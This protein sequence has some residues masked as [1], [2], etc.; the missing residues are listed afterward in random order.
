MIPVK[1]VAKCIWV[2]GIAITN[3]CFYHGIFAAT[4]VAALSL[5]SDHRI[6]FCWQFVVVEQRQTNGIVIN[7]HCLY[8]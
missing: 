8:L 4:I 7:W 6:L 3:V 1:V 2:Y 5:C